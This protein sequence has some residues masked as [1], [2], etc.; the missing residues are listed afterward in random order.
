MKGRRPLQRSQVS[1]LWC[2]GAVVLLAGCNKGGSGLTDAELD[3]IA[4]TEK[5]R[6]VEE[7]GGLVLVVGGETITSDEVINASAGK[8][9]EDATVAELLGAIAQ[10]ND[11]NQFKR[12]AREPLR[13]VVTGKISGILLYQ[14]AKRELGSV[15]DEALDKLVEKEL[16]KFILKH[17][18]N[19]AEADEALK[20]MGTDRE[21]FKAEQ[22]KVMITQSYLS[23]KLPYRKPVTY[24]ELLDYY[25]RHKDEL[26]FEPAS[27]Q[28]SLIDIEIAKTKISDLGQNRAELARKLVR[29]VMAKLKAGEDFAELAKQYSHGP[30]RELGGAWPA[31]QPDSLA[32]PYDILA[33]RA[34]D[35]EPNEVA[36]PIEKGGHIFI[37]KLTARREQRYKPLEEVQ[38]QVHRRILLE[39][40]NEAI[41]RLNERL[42]REASIGRTDEFVDFCLDKIY[43]MSTQADETKEQTPQ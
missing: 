3:R 13:N 22:K 14:H 43:R 39:R 17:G 41:T 15:A 34:K 12:L 40:R 7:A 18:G 23:T 11:P 42:L 28:F 10:Q 8:E 30:R 27:L 32:E 24:G 37:M 9:G 33:E 21:G 6:L 36:G 16:R 4:M 38:G 20:Q 35:L 5:I 31:L 1:A 25:E 29:E 19:E 26:F 2:L